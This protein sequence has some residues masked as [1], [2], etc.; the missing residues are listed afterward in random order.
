MIDKTQIIV[1]TGPTATGKSELGIQLA[2]KI[3]GEI[4]SADSMQIYKNM[5]IGTAKP[6]AEEMCG[7]PHHM[8]DVVSPLEDYSVARYIRDAE[9]CIDS[10]IK[11]GNFPIIVGGTGLYIDSLISGRTFS[12]RVDTAE[13]LCLENE[14]DKTGGDAMLEKLRKVDAET[15]Q[16]LHPNDK[17]RI[18]RALEIH[19]S[20]GKTISEHNNETKNLSPRYKTLKFA[21]NYSQRAVL[22]S[23]INKRVDKMISMGLENEVRALLK[24]GLTAKNTSMQAIGYK[25]ISAAITDESDIISAVEKIKMESRRYAKRQ[26]TWLRRD[27]GTH[28]ILWDKS[29]DFICG[30]NTISEL[31]RGIK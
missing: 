27:S 8:I 19:N 31:L 24:M 14:F 17:K 3:N 7:V 5:N 12:A 10:I 22:Y 1:I 26:L 4:V 29:P 15:A 21:L 2:K 23:K 9:S 6:N 16:R 25:E 18:I 20:T 13:R 30:I 28:W 11:R